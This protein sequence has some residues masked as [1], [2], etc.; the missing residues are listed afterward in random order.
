MQ[1]DEKAASSI[2][3]GQ[4]PNGLV[5]R[6]ARLKVVPET[7]IR[8]KK[9]HEMLKKNLVTSALILILS[10]AAVGPAL[11]ADGVV[12]VNEAGREE[13]ML[14]PRVGEVVAQRIIEHREENGPFKAASDLLLVRGIGDR[15]FDL[16]EPYVRVEGPTTL[17]EKVSAR[18]ATAAKAD[19]APKARD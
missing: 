12:N 19:E 18:G 4:S 11:A 5:G 16:L 17:K 14:L 15:T 13:L 3:K 1:E 9:G 2:G 8:S 10:L 6:G 7:S